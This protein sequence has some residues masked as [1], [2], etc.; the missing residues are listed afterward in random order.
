MKIF[1]QLAQSWNKFAS[2]FNCTVDPR[3]RK[4]EHQI[5]DRLQQLT[6]Y[7]MN[8]FYTL[9][10][11]PPVVQREFVPSLVTRL[12][13]VLMDASCGEWRLELCNSPCLLWQASNHNLSQRYCMPHLAIVHQ[14]ELCQ[15]I[16]AGSWKLEGIQV[17]LH[18]S[19]CQATYLLPDQLEL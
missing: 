17:D 6:A 16:G 1:W 14:L 8:R 2:V 15:E 10:S 13:K 5:C 19:A 3:S 12:E 9:F 4:T 7:I 11:L 18:Q